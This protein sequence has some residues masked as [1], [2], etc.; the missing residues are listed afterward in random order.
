MK[1]GITP[2]NIA[3]L[4]FL[5][6]DTCE[7]FRVVNAKPHSP[8]DRGLTTVVSVAQGVGTVLQFQK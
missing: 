8:L 5:V 1:I 3:V 6:S 4:A 7:K 2:K